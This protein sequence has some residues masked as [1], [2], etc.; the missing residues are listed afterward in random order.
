MTLGESHIQ[1]KLNTVTVFLGGF[2]ENSREKNICMVLL[3]KSWAFLVFCRVAHKTMEPSYFSNL[4]FHL[5]G[6]LEHEF[7]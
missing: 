7:Y 5:V 2:K 4:S 1:P 3:D 6:G